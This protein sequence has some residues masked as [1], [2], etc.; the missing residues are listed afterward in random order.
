MPTQLFDWNEPIDR[1]SYQRVAFLWLVLPLA[2]PLLVWLF[3]SVPT[4]TP[5]TDRFFVIW[6]PMMLASLGLVLLS[7]RRLLDFGV[8]RAIACLAFIAGAGLAL[9][10][11]LTIVPTP[12]RTAI[13]SR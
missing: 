2:L 11:I 12:S 9:Y 3:S 5:G 6:I 4:D 13:P 1:D 10:I 8:A 7:M